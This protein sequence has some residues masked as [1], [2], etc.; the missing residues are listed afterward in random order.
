MRMVRVLF[1]GLT[2]FP[3]V[4]DVLERLHEMGEAQCQHV[5]YNAGHG[6][7]VLRTKRTNRELEDR[8]AAVNEAVLT[9]VEDLGGEAC[10]DCQQMVA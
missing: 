10:H 6:S 7:F 3:Q 2:T 4:L 5:N 1:S 9:G 8:L